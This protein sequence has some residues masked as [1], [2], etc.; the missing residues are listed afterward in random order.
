MVQLDGDRQEPDPGLVFCSLN[1]YQ[2]GYIYYTI[3]LDPPQV[4]NLPTH[5]SIGHGVII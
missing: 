5:S 3:W 4:A 1:I 2:K